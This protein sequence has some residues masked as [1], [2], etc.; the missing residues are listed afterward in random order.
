VPYL[1]QAGQQAARRGVYQE[2]VA[3]YEQA[4]HALQQL[5]DNREV[6]EQA[7]DLRFDLRDALMPL[8]DS[9]R[10]RDHLRQA[11]VLAEALGDQ[12]RLGQI[13]G[14]M[15]FCLRDLGDPDGSLASAQRA[16]PIAAALGDVSRQVAA[17]ISM[18][19]VYLSALSDYRRA[20]AVFRRSV[21]MLR[22]ALPESFGTAYRQSVISHANL[23]MCLAELGAFAEGQVHGEAALRLAE[24]AE[25]PYSLAQACAAVGYF[26]LR[27]GALPQAIRVLERGWALSEAVHLPLSTR[28]CTARLGVAYALSGR[29]PEALP[30]LEWALEQAMAMRRTSLYPLLAV[31]LGEGYMLAGRVAEAIPLGKQAFEAAQ[32]QE[33]QGYQA[34]ALRL[35]GEIAAH[36]DPPE[37]EQATAHYQHALALAE[38]IGMRPLQA[39]CHHGLGTLYA[40]T[41][42]REQAR[43][44][45]S[46]AVEMYHAME[47][48]FW[49]PQVEAALAIVH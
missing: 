45:L 44:E 40:E 47:M 36:G 9:R 23:A 48:K 15:A 33:Q 30:L 29:V 4:L 43:A 10:I 34:Y 25:H 27:Q 12:R 21:E 41:G 2:A 20:A 7:I 18:G 13:A 16:L 8:D 49:L 42:Q 32:G 46:A 5:P 19:E 39:H 3:F 28:L 6:S 17:N 14:Y 37:I 24:A 38:E 31:R 11:E 35:L 26:Y 22:G 1:R